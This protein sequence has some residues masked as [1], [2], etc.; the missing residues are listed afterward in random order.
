MDINHSKLASILNPQWFKDF[1]AFKLNIFPVIV[2]FIYI[3]SVILCIYGG[4]IT[5]ARGQAVLG[6]GMIL[7]YPILI[8]LVLEFILL[9]FTMV[10]ILREIRD[11]IGK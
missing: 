9:L 1:F 4:I 3:L 7:L 10:D 5:C 6:I 11:K 2:R 8:H